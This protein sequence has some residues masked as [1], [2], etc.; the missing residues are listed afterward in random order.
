MKLRT[1]IIL[2]VVLL[3]TVLNVAL[4]I[5]FVLRNRQDSIDLL[6]Q[7]IENTSVLLNQVNAG[8]LYD[9]DISKL[10]TNLKSFFNEPEIVAISLK[11]HNGN[12]NIHYEEPDFKKN[13]LIKKETAILYNNEKI[14]VITTYYTLY[15][16]DKRLAKLVL[17]ITVSSIIVILITSVTLYFFL[18]KI[19]KPITDLT[20][21]SAEIAEG[22]LEKDINI[23]S[24][25]EIGKLS[26]SFL[27]MRDSVKNKIHSLKVENKERKLAEKEL[28]KSQQRLKKAQSVAKIG[29][30]EL[31]LKDNKFYISE[32][33][34]TIFD[35]EADNFD[36][37]Y[38]G[39]L[40]KIHPDDIV[41]VNN[42]YM[43][44]VKNKTLYNTSYRLLLKDGSIRFISGICDTT[45]DDSGDAIRSVGTVQDITDSKL[46]EKEKIK[47]EE[48]LSHSRKMD[49]IGQLAGGVAHDFNNMLCGI[50]GAAQLL[51]T[52]KMKLNKQGLEYVDMI[53]KASTRAAELTAKLLAFGRKGAVAST[54]VDIH[55]ILNDTL[56]ILN[57]TIN[58]NINIALIKNAERYMLVGDH[59]GLENI[60][61]NLCINA[62]HALPNGGKITI[63]TKN[64]CLD[65][66]YCK[67]SQF[68]IN[69][70]EYI[71]ITVA[72]TGSGIKSEHLD[73]IFD[74]FFTT[75]EQGEGTGLGLAAVYGTVLNHKGAISVESEVGGGT[76]FHLFF[77]CTEG[78]VKSNNH[79]T[80]IVKGSGKILLVDDED[81]I[82]RTCQHMLEYLGY[83][84]LTAEDGEGAVDI[85]KKNYKDIDLVVM[86]M[87]MPKMNGS[88]AF[89]KM[90][91]IDKKCKVVISSG[92][93]K[94]ENVDEMQ[95]LGLSGFIKKPFQHYE[96]SK[97]LADILG[98][99]TEI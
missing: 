34:Y 70:G 74:P 7:R 87:I 44:S 15:C 29:D 60:F 21:L 16:I 5:T 46:A 36:N 82:R 53:L 63:K 19:T 6:E 78:N 32:E 30:W 35:L 83:E 37:S 72:D 91:A 89:K 2:I 99:G 75:K 41:S 8:P 57:K 95:E 77:L 3:S 42:A 86:D 93:T 26:Q 59:T 40:K 90:K 50:R 97:L 1:K 11:E 80:E 58:K 98:G 39:F 45:Y 56:A 10:E 27:M 85:F 71:E 48:Q 13:K 51:A 38:E 76:T 14:G 94:D 18:R 23:V 54:A 49:A 25:D 69:P 17:Q 22:N 9:M 67:K 62:S 68:D 20:E 12:I 79:S 33:I 92:F 28:R 55:S 81:I 47:L 64:I 88:E 96:L 73:Q 31:D 84:V 52:S 43:E 24:S 66:K 4:L 65:K 61:I